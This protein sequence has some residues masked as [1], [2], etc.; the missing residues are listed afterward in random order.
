MLINEDLAEQERLNNNLDQE[1]GCDEAGPVTH[2]SSQVY[3]D[4]LCRFNEMQIAQNDELVAESAKATGLGSNPFST[5]A[6]H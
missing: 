3:Q 1:E 5:P 2:D 4:S 6:A